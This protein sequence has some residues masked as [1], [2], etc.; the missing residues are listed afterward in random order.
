MS[1]GTDSS[2]ATNAMPGPQAKSPLGPSQDEADSPQFVVA[3]AEEWLP[4]CGLML[5]G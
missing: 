4:D 2:M 5:E 1:A 3:D